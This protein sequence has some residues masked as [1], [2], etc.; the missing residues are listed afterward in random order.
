MSFTRQPSLAAR[1]TESTTVAWRGGS[2][3]PT[4]RGHVA[5][6]GSCSRLPCPQLQPSEATPSCPYVQSTRLPSPDSRFFGRVHP[7]RML[8]PRTGDSAEEHIG[9]VAYAT[10]CNTAPLRS[11]QPASPVS[12][13]PPSPPSPFCPF[14][15]V[16]LPT[17][18]PR[19]GAEPPRR[20]LGNHKPRPP[21]SST[22]IPRDSRRAASSPC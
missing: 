11:A 8:F 6:G 21:V 4:Y 20:R 2:R 18:S 13:S 9:G 22:A 5:I 19:D 14:A 12:S 10:S 15:I 16:K 3:L 7:P 1:T 17:R